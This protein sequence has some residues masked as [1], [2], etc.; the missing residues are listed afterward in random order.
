MHGRAY[1]ERYALIVSVCV[2]VGVFYRKDAK[3]QSFR[4]GFFRY[5]ELDIACPSAGGD[6]R[7]SKSFF[8]MK[9]LIVISIVALTL[10]ASCH[11][12][13]SQAESS[14]DTTTFH[15]DWDAMSTTLMQRMNLEAG[16]KV[17][18]VA[19]PGRFD[20]MIPLLREKILAA[21]GEYLGTISVDT[22][23]WP[24]AWRTDFVNGTKN[25]SVDAM[26]DYMKDADIAIM[27]P[28]ADVSH[29]PYQAMQKVLQRG[30]GR[31]IHFHWSGAYS[32][33]G[34]ALPLTENVDKV[35]QDAL[36]NTN[37]NSISV[38]H[39]FFEESARRSV[40]RVTTPVGTD[41]TFSIGD[42]PVTKQN[43]DASKVRTAHARNL[44]D[45]E[46]ELPAGAIRVAP[47]E[48][49]VNGVIAFP[50]AQWNGKDVTGLKLTIKA[51]KIVAIKASSGLED[52][53]EELRMAGPAGEWFREFALGF[54]PLLAIPQNGPQWIPYYGYGAGVVRLSL[55]DNTE[56]GGKVKGGYVRWNFFTDATV[57]IGERNIVVDGKMLQ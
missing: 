38:L 41:I 24:Q 11:K 35:Y 56:L 7:R 50:D 36:L 51:G 2:G 13:E 29:T 46:I 31:T 53:K 16:E 22:I 42:R 57:S 10:V 3:T 40:I 23:N 12:K 26:A 45:R 55:G 52:V 18:I 5:S 21:G 48:E 39:Q 6:I 43:G 37:Y 49:T 34:A 9:K 15:L 27:M 47:I 44:I 17:L 1:V 19:N 30:S 32:L 33:D 4:S 28:G 14:A 54:N 25:M 20:E 8:P